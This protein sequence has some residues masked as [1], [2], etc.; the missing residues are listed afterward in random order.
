MS[1]T[2]KCSSVVESAVKAVKE[3]SKKLTEEQIK[4]TAKDNDISYP[5]LRSILEVECKGS[6]FLANGKPTILFERH[7]FWRELGKID[8]YSVRAKIHRLRPDLC[9]P[10]PT[11]RGGYGSGDYQ[12]QRL[13]DIKALITHVLPDCDEK[14]SKIIYD[15]AL[16]A[17]SWGLGQIMGFNYEKAGFNSLDEFVQAMETSEQ[18]QLEAV[19]NL[20]T[21]W[22]LKSA[23]QCKQYR[24]IAKAWNGRLYWKDGYHKKLE[25]NYLRY[26]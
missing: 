3:V 12:V 26:A 7:I 2:E 17:T 9:D 13:A 20:L 25:R 14:T 15:C 6:G 23:M 11:K 5:M 21:N 22:G 24:R 4:Q 10:A 1:E 16:K 8:F 18:K 19:V